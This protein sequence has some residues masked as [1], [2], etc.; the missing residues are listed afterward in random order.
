M[1]GEEPLDE[2][3]GGA[4]DETGAEVHREAEEDEVGDEVRAG[5]LALVERRAAS[6]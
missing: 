2:R 4:L 3:V 6:A 5:A 1:H